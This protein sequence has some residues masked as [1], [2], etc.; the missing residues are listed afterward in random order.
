MFAWDGRWDAYCV[1][2]PWDAALPRQTVLGWMRVDIRQYGFHHVTATNICSSHCRNWLLFLFESAQTFT[3][4]WFSAE[5][6]TWTVELHHF[7]SAS[8]AWTTCITLTLTQELWS[9][10]DRRLFTYSG[11]PQ[12][13][14][15]LPSL[16]H[17]SC[18]S[19]VCTITVCLITQIWCWT[20]TCILN[21]WCLS[22]V[23]VC[24]ELLV[25]NSKYSI[26]LDIKCNIRKQKARRHSPV[27]VSHHISAQPLGQVS[28]DPVQLLWGRHGVEG[29]LLH[30]RFTEAILKNRI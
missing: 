8:W 2:T 10:W 12:T 7:L 13:S 16:Q 4:L 30:V 3:H 1:V 9:L 22:W 6:V 29:Q 5:C 17:I 21:Q 28:S 18:I 19:S 11:S 25:R 27:A 26:F 20:F 24:N 14:E 23:S 15:K